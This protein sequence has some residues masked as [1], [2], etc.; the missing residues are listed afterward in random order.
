MPLLCAICVPKIIKVGGHLTSIK[1][2]LK[3]LR[4]RSYNFGAMGNN[5][6]KLF[7]LTCREAGMITWVHFFGGL[8]PLK[9]GRAKTVQNLVR[10]RATS[11]FDRKYLR[12]GGSYRQADNGVINSD[13]SHVRRKKIGED[14][15]TNKNV[16]GAHVDPCLLYTSPSPRD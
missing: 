8:P 2:S 11:H 4:M 5:L 13:H 16:I 10:F 9:F 1:I 7:Q 14:W 6:T 12:N 15:S 3:I